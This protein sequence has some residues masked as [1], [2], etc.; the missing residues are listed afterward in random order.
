MKR[1]FALIGILAIMCLWGCDGTEKSVPNQ[2]PQEE[3]PAV[4]GITFPEETGRF[5]EEGTY[6]KTQLEK[7]GH[8]VIL[9]YAGQDAK[10]Q[11][12]QLNQMLSDGAS[13]LV[14]TAVDPVALADVLQQAE[15]IGVAVISYDRRLPNCPGIDLH[16]GFDSYQA[17]QAIAKHV[18]TQM[19]LAT[20]QEEQR[21]HT[22]EFFMGAPEDDNA[23]LR[24]Q[25]I[26]SVLQPYLNSGVLRCL[27]GRTGFEDTCTTQWSDEAAR[28]DC[29]RYLDKH[30]E[31]QPLEI[32]VAASDTLASG[33]AQALNI[34]RVKKL[35]LLT[36]QEINLESARR[37]ASGQQAIS[38]VYD[39]DPVSKM[40]VEAVN[41]FLTGKQPQ[42][43]AEGAYLFM[44]EMV[45][46]ENY[47]KL[48][49]ESGMFTK[50]QLS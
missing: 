16:I 8:Q 42:T 41:A 13:C 21:S 23:Y 2:P 18:E 20:A 22:V 17:G 43:N 19:N 15:K 44:P 50:E 31:K 38:A 47:E 3:K 37:I 30:Y 11:H 33:C 12:D 7:L 24:Y 10:T 46:G 26:M 35:P 49:I 14:I 34:A 28:D 48:L 32:C 45:T 4:V 27:S 6:L 1:C 29:R 39:Y 9:N 25:G 40:C 36:G 5:A